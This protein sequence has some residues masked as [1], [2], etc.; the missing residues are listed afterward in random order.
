VPGEEEARERKEPLERP[1]ETASKSSPTSRKSFSPATDLKQI[2]LSLKGLPHR[3]VLSLQWCDR[4]E[5]KQY[6]NL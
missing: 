1:C 6:K 5:Q 3:F 4:E 2:I